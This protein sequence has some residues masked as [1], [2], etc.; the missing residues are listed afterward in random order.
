[1]AAEVT[2][3]T[4]EGHAQ[5][6]ST[7]EK[8]L[9]WLF[10]GVL[11]ALAPFLALLI[12]DITNSTPMSLASFFG[13][14]ELLIVATIIAAGGIG[15]LFGT[16]VRRERRMAKLIVLFCCI[17][18]LVATCFWF[19]AVSTLVATEHPPQHPETV[20]WGSIMLFAFGVLAGGSALLL[21]EARER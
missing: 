8:V 7:P 4:P 14:G 12:N 6:S 13:H 10:F 16:E 9:R 2:G 19:A 18:V 3:V 11:M 5:A 1:M 21:S 20:A 17:A 15:D